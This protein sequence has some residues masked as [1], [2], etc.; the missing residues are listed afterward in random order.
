MILHIKALS[1]SYRMLHD[2]QSIAKLQ[3]I[4]AV[5]AV[6]PSF[7]LT[8]CSHSC[9]RLLPLQCIANI[10]YPSQRIFVADYVKS[11]PTRVNQ[12]LSLTSSANLIIFDLMPQPISSMH[13]YIKKKGPRAFSWDWGTERKNR[14]FASPVVLC[15]TARE[16]L[17]K[18]MKQS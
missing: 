1:N 14:S 8:V 15:L 18:Q 7:T 5:V 9:N 2:L 12:P 11:S 17:L 6:S 3:S 10:I 13:L 16:Y 4:A